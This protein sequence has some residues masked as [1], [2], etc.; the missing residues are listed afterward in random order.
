MGVVCQQK[1][2]K[3][4]PKGRSSYKNI[5]RITK[6]HIN[7]KN[8][9]NH[10]TKARKQRPMPTGSF[11][12]TRIGNPPKS[13]QQD[14]R[15]QIPTTNSGTFGIASG[16]RLCFYWP[17]E[18][19]DHQYLHIISVSVKTSTVVDLTRDTMS[20]STH[21][22]CIRTILCVAFQIKC[23]VWFLGGGKSVVY[24]P[25]SCDRLCFAESLS[26]YG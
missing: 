8:I 4:A 22:E 16:A 1:T 15:A 23:L 12:I 11:G 18:L 26:F 3:K 20:N 17:L 21:I 19:C 6:Y 9:D 7:V 13:L 24:R 14:S 5:Y 2:Q 10:S 25:I